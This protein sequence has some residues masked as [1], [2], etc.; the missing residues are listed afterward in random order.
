VASLVVIEAYVRGF[1][2]WGAWSTAIALLPFAWL[3]GRRHVL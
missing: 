3:L 1:D 2:G